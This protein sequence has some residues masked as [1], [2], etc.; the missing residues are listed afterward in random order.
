MG[1]KKMENPKQLCVHYIVS[2]R[3]MAMNLEFFLL[4]GSDWF[5]NEYN[6]F[7]VTQSRAVSAADNI[8]LYGDSPHWIWVVQTEL[9]DQ[10]MQN[11]SFQGIAV[12]KLVQQPELNYNAYAEARAAAREYADAVRDY[13]AMALQKGE[14]HLT[15]D[16]PRISAKIR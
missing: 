6:K 11:R 16:D 9:F 12:S 10:F 1:I 13:S 2:Q 3:V 4:V 5:E 15:N 14:I 8:P 7:I